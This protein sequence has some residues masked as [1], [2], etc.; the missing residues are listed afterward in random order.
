MLIDKIPYIWY[1]IIILKVKTTNNHNNIL[2][3]KNNYI[4][5]NG[6]MSSK[7]FNKILKGR[8]NYEAYNHNG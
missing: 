2:T 6:K 1:N 3:Y 4:I 5:Y 7:K 8:L